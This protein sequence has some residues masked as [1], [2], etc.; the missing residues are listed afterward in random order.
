M[1]EEASG[2]ERITVKDVN[3]S[4]IILF[5]TYLDAVVAEQDNTFAASEQSNASAHSYVSLPT[6]CLFQRTSWTT[7]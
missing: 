1:S 4:S 7:S 6:L 2:L 3:S 5:D